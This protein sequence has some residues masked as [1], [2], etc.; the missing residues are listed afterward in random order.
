MIAILSPEVENH[1][2]NCSNKYKNNYRKLR[3]ERGKVMQKRTETRVVWMVTNY[4]RHPYILQLGNVACD[5]CVCN[6]GMPVV[7][8]LPPLV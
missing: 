1:Q 6:V 2:N 3:K 5:A 4:N 8:C 7:V